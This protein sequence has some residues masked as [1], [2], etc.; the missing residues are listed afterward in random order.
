MYGKS[1][2]HNVYY[3][4]YTVFRDK[5]AQKDEN[6]LCEDKQNAAKSVL[7]H[8]TLEMIPTEFGWVLKDGQQDFT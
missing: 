7:S 3:A 1:Q 4:H 5:Y 8:F 2:L 6:I